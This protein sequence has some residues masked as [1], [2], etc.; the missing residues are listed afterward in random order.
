MIEVDPGIDDCHDDLRA[1]FFDVPSG[2]RLQQGVVPGL[3]TV[4]GVVGSDG[5]A[6]QV[7]RFRRFH[8]G[9]GSVAADGLLH[10]DLR[11]QLHP[12]H[13]QPR[14]TL[15]LPGSRH[16]GRQGLCLRP[17]P[18][19]H[20]HLA[21]HVFARNGRCLAQGDPIVCRR[22]EQRQDERQCRH[23]LCHRCPRSIV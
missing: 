15:Q 8:P 2:R 22:D 19:D 20:Q 23:P 13:S 3:G 4:P 7:V 1:P 6:H 11:R 10:A 9:Q 18:L 14:Q 16:G 12:P 5:G 21:G 17:R